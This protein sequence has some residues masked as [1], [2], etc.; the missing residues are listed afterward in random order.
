M[1]SWLLCEACIHSEKEA[2]WPDEKFI[3]I[4]NDCA[5]SCIGLVAHFVSDSKTVK[6]TVFDCFL[7]CRECYNECMLHPEADIAY[8]GEV[9]NTCAEMIK[10]LLIFN[11]N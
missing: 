11:L 2:L 7:Y 9:C 3:K 5:Q 4:C 8:C 1:N 10:E 6:Q